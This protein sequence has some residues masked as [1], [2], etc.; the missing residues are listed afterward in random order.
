MLCNCSN[1]TCNLDVAAMDIVMRHF[2]RTCQTFSAVNAYK[3]QLQYCLFNDVNNATL[4]ENVLQNLTSIVTGL[5]AT[6]RYLKEIAITEVITTFIHYHR[7][8]RINYNN[9]ITGYSVYEVHS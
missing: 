9:V 1:S 6:A 7:H 2:D 8:I 3:Y 4:P 5:Q